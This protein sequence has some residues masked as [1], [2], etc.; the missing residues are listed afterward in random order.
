MSHGAADIWGK[1]P[2]TLRAALIDLCLRDSINLYLVGGTVRDWLL[3]I[4]PQD[5]DLCLAASAQAVAGRLR[6][7]LGEGAIVDLSGN[8]EEAARLVWRGFQVDFASFR[9]GAASI[10][11]DLRLR[12]FTVN[13]MAVSLRDLLGGTALVIDPTNGRDDLQSRRLR[14]CPGAFAADPLRLLRGYRLS[15]TLGFSLDP[16]S[17]AAVAREATAIDGVAAERISGELRQI[18]AAPAAALT[19][20]AMDE[21]RLLPQLFPELYL[22]AGIT[23][24]GFHHLDVL[25][26]SLLALTKMEEILVEPGRF[27]PGWSELFAEYLKNSAVAARLR[28][29]ALFHDLG[30]PATRCLPPGDLGRVTFYGHDQEGE[31]LFREFATRSRWSR[32][33]TEG[34]GSLIA[35]H[36]HPFHLCNIGR[37]GKVS[38]KAILRLCRRA[39]GDLAGLFLLAMADS[40]ASLGAEKPPR[41]EEELCQLFGQVQ[42]LYRERI[43]EALH[44]PPLLSGRDLIESFAL[45]PGPLFRELLDQVTTARVE[46]R[47]ADREQALAHVAA[48]LADRGIGVGAAGFRLVK[49]S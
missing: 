24:P 31:Q 9:A 16:A 40:L 42:T 33:E 29:A 20:R 39:G 22:G 13:A 17:R 8:G 15:A 48:L 32:E 44:G 19:V 10:E 26:H 11:E 45:V 21:D 30:K 6:Q 7:D 25:G 3:G 28:W 36:M 1:T 43:A 46:G 5:L 34:V 2:P 18:F 4:L 23:Q 37:G 14:H 27:F 12:D 38:A 47:V 35:M 49:E 41:M